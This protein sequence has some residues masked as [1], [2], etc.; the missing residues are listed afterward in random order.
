LDMMYLA[1]EWCPRAGHTVPLGYT[2]IQSGSPRRKLSTCIVDPAG[3]PFER[4]S[5]T[6][7]TSPFLPQPLHKLKRRKV[8]PLTGHD[9]G[10]RFGDEQRV[11]LRNCVARMTLEVG[12]HDDEFKPTGQ[13]GDNRPASGEDLHVGD[14]VRESLI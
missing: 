10:I 8:Y 2:A 7:I 9:H 14:L 11:P 6:T 5:L 13:R 1:R 12:E 3:F 4:C